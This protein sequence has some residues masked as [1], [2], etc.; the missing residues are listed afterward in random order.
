MQTRYCDENSVCSSVCLSVCHTRVLWQNGKKI[1]PDLYTIRKNSWPS[2]L[3]RRMVGGDDPFRDCNPGLICQSRD[4]G[5]EKCKSRDPG[6]EC[7]DW[8]PDFEL[9]KISSN[10]LVWVSWWVLESWSICWSPVLTYYYYV[11]NCK[12]FY[13]SSFLSSDTISPL[14]SAQWVSNIGQIIKSVCVSVSQSVSEWVSQSVIP[15]ILGPPPHL[16]NNSS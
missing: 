5:I 12:Y 16:V 2:F 11:N 7:R 10:S 9:V 14:L 13:L 15:W 6:I 4:F 8:V 3:R 1:C